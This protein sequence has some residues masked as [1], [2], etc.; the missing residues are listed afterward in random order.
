VLPASS[1]AATQAPEQVHVG[2]GAGD[3][4][5]ARRSDD[6]ARK[7]V[8]AG[9]SVFSYQPTDTA[10]EGQP[11]NSRFRDDTGGNSQTVNMGFTIDVGQ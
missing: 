4:D 7:N 1:A 2:L 11:G 3:N 5:L 9:Q 6:L 10:A 8:V